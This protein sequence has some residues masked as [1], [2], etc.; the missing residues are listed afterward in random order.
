M[1]IFRRKIRQTLISNGKIIKYFL[2]VIGE[3]ILVVIGILIALGVNNR[4]NRR[5]NDLRVERFSDKLKVQLEDNLSAVND[6]IETHEIYYSDSKRL[7]AIVGE[8]KDVNNEAKIDSLVLFNSYDYHLNLDM[9]ILIESRENGDLAL[10]S[11]D[12]LSQSI[13][14]LITYYNKIIED[15]RITNS[16]L[17]NHFAP[18]LSKN[19]NLKNL[20]HRISDD[21]DLEKSKI[22]KGDNY[23]MLT[24]QEFENLITLRLIHSQ[25][26]LNSYI[27]LKEIIL[28]T[29]KL[30]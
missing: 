30:L 28:D 19:Y 22:Y 6:Y 1:I 10:I 29:Y 2:Y 13:Y 15:E 16:N 24:D 9:N 17:N 7:L 4:N 27:E 20:F 5:L 8:T 14:H 3:I 11:K 12:S 18:Y 25:E 26:L 23:K 21:E